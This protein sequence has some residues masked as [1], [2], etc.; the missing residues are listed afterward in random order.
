MLQRAEAERVAHSSLATAA[1]AC[2]FA[3]GGGFLTATIGTGADIACYAF[4]VFGWNVCLKADRSP[5]PVGV[6]LWY[7]LGAGRGPTM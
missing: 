6:V 7:S 2:T 4:G 1:L 3:L 5:H